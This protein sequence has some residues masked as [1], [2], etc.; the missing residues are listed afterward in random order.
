MV[1]AARLSERVCGLPSADSVRV[2]E[3]V[4]AAGLPTAP[5][6][7][8]APRWLELM[9]R[10]KKVADGRMRFVLLERM[11]SAVVRTDVATDTLTGV[12]ADRGM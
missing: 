10:D 12:L 11:G 2:R 7:M 6:A 1:I 8:A 5:P 4:A 9:G 3:L